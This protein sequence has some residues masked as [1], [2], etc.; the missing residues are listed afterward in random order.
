METNNDILEIWSK[1]R[2]IINNI[3]PNSDVIEKPNTSKYE[4]YKYK[5]KT[6]K[7]KYH[8][9]FFL[10]LFLKKAKNEIEILLDT[11]KYPEYPLVDPKNITKPVHA[12]DH[13]PSKILVRSE[14][15]NLGKYTYKH[16]KD[17]IKQCYDNL[18]LPK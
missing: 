14:D 9:V 10:Y 11:G 7:G 8:R 15:I 5:S 18:N 12:W 3:G 6:R 17:L 16:I 2:D 4:S 13:I 1:L